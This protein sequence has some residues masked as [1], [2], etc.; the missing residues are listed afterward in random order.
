[1]IWPYEKWPPMRFK[2]G[3]QAGSKG[4]HGPIRYT[5][6]KYNPGEIIEF[7][8]TRPKGFHGIHRF[9]IIA[10]RMAEAKGSENERTEIV[11]TIDMQ[12]SGIGG[13]NWILF[14]RPLHNALLEDA[15]DK[16]ENHFSEVK[17]KTS[18]N[19]WVKFLRWIM[20]QKKV[21]R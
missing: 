11:H 15:L 4:G 19:P 20:K 9:E 6:N 12:T 7:R 14:I 13:L 17:K 10:S 5:I 21:I 8:F 2:E 1:M 3:L 18:W 16:V